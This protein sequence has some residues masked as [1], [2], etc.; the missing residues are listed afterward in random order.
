M[1]IVVSYDIR[2]DQR[3]NKLA[4]ILKDFGHR[5]QYSVF[6]CDLESKYVE[7]MIKEA[8]SIID[9][10][11]DSLRIYRLCNACIDKIET[12]GNPNRFDKKNNIVI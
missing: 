4:E 1:F 7:E 11:Y 12:Y 8:T 5:V 10:E 6:E 3:R 9:W 2:D